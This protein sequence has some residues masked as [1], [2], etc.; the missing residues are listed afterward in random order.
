MKQKIL[1]ASA[2]LFIGTTYV[3]QAE[4]SV[5]TTAQSFNR[6][7]CEAVTLDSITTLTSSQNLLSA[8]HNATKCIGFIGTQGKNGTQYNDDPFNSYGTNI[9]Y[10]GDGLLNGNNEFFSGG[11]FIGPNDYQALKDPTKPVDPGWINVLSFSAGEKDKITGDVSDPFY[12]YSKSGTGLI[13]KPTLNIADL[14][15]FTLTCSQGSLGDCNA[16]IWRLETKTNIIQDVVTLLG[17]ATF[18]HLAFSIKAGTGFVVYDFNFK[19]IFA[20]ENNSALNFSTPY[21]LSGGFNTADLGNKGISHLTVL[22]RDPQDLR[23]VPEPTPLAIVGLG[24]LALFIRTK[25]SQ[26]RSV[27]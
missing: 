11:E 4:A 25:L 20:T 16:G 12:I 26:V 5:I 15:T 9:G 8:K 6:N 22:A 18:D 10:F 27:K 23:T 17:P 14:L 13:G 1:T 7:G 3:G 19:D 24:L 2:I 21:I